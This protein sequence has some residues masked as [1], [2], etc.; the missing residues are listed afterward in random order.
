MPD[1]PSGYS[2]IK[3]DNYIIQPEDFYNCS[4]WQS[5]K[6]FYPFK[7]FYDSGVGR[8]IFSI[9]KDLGPFNLIRV[10]TKKKRFETDKPYPF[11]Y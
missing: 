7:K 3:N 4:G 9:Q 5:P 10:A 8:T 1:L 2:V 11:G 6:D